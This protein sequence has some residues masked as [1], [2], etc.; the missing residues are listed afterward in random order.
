M[1][2]KLRSGVFGPPFGGLMGN[3]RVS[4]ITRWKARDRLPIGYH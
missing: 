2:K 1:R 3:A 4:S